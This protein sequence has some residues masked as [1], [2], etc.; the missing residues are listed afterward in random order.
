MEIVASHKQKLG[1]VLLAAALVGVA[2]MAGV[3][4]LIAWAALSVDRVEVVREQNLVQR[5]TA[6][7]LER[8]SEDINSAAIWNESVVAMTGDPDLRWLQVNFGDYFADYMDHAATLVLDGDGAVVLASR[9]SEPVG[10]HELATFHQAAQPLVARVRDESATPA[11]RGALG[12]EGAV[13]A[14]GLVRVE[15]EVWLVGAATITPED[16]VVARLDADPIVVSGY[17]L[18]ALIASIGHDLDLRDVAFTPDPEAARLSLAGPNGEWIGGLTWTPERIGLSLLAEGARIMACVIALLALGWAWLMLWLRRTTTAMA[19]AEDSLIRAKNAA[20]AANAVKSRFLANVSHEL[21]TPLNGI[22]GIAEVMATQDLTPVQ[23]Q[24]LD[25]IRSSGGRL[26]E[27]IEELLQLS[28][29]ERG[30]IV[31]RAEVFDLDALAS[32]VVE[33]QRPA[34]AAKGVALRQRAPKLGLRRGDP[35]HLAQALNQLMENAVTYT[36]AGH[37]ELAVADT[38]GVVRFTVEDTGAGLEAAKLAEVFGLFVQ[39]DD[40]LTKPAEGLGAGLP[41]CRMLVVA[42]GGRVLA[43]SKP[44]EGSRFVVELPLPPAGRTDGQDAP[45]ADARSFREASLQIAG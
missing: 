6:A 13:S 43:D 17:P 1:R 11:R 15:G 7:A 26:T 27:L 12:F 41:L 45:P 35:E 25:L 42:M 2:A 36:S 40:S 33:R 19:E 18:D 38:D 20:E 4:M 37:V 8:I 16:A 23:K 31:T 10:V 28:R 32:S 21:R 22:V 3:A 14:T 24:H 30:Q 9:D 5:R 29:L 39:G 34:A 44:G